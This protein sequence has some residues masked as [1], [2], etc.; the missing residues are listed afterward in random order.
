[1]YGFRSYTRRLRPAPTINTFSALQ[2]A[3]YPPLFTSLPPSLLLPRVIQPRT[4]CV[5]S[6][7]PLFTSDLVRSRP[8]PI[9]E[10]TA[11]HVLFGGLLLLERALI[12]SFPRSVASPLLKL[13]ISKIL[14]IMYKNLENFS[15]DGRRKM[16]TFVPSYSRLDSPAI[17]RPS[18]EIFLFLRSFKLVCRGLRRLNGSRKI[19]RERGSVKP[20]G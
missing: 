17:K 6:L 15:H 9:I 19:N 16:E 8:V 5:V 3:R 10:S 2:S 13:N 20:M 1:M 18:R 12:K 4:R 7:I 11:R 14:V